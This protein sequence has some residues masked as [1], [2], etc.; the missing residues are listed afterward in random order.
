MDISEERRQRWEKEEEPKL[1]GKVS[2]RTLLLI[3]RQYVY[4]DLYK[5]LE[6][7]TDEEFLSHFGVGLKTLAEIRSVLAAPAK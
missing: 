5:P 2:R 6:S 3:A 7:I 4:G 1:L